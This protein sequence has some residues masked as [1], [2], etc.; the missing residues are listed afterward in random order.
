M[1]I[2]FPLAVLLVFIAGEAGPS[3]AGS[4]AETCPFSKDTRTMQR[5]QNNSEDA[6]RETKGSTIRMK[7]VLPERGMHFKWRLQPMPVKAREVVEGLASLS[8][9]LEPVSNASDTV[10]TVWLDI[11]NLVA[12]VTQTDINWQSAPPVRKDARPRTVG[13]N[14][15]MS[16]YKD[17]MRGKVCLFLQELCSLTPCF[18]KDKER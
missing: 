10:R 3:F 18:W 17:F 2:S 11:S 13:L 9:A 15:V 5:Y 1:D 12:I 8:R 6:V 7:I 16:V 14:M 4:Q